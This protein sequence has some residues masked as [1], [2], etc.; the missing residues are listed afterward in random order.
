MLKYGEFKNM[1][2]DSK[3]L[4]EYLALEPEIMIAKALLDTRNKQHSIQK[5]YL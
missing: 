1:F 2:K 3:V 5:T 4:E